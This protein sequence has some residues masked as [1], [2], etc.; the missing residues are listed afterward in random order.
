MKP[1][2]L[3]TGATGFAG[4]H[5]ADHL[6]AHGYPVRV[7]VRETSDVS[8]VHPEAERFVGDVRDPDSLVA[9]VRGV[10]WVF[11]FGGLIRARNRQEFMRANAD[12]TRHLYEAF[13]R[14]SED[15][16]L[17]LFC[18]SLAAV[19]PGRG[20]KLLVEDDPPHPVTHYGASKL[21]AEEFL[22]ARERVEAVTSGARTR[23]V[24]V[25][26]PAV[27][28]PRDP[29]NLML[30]RAISR[31]WIP[32]PA[33]RGARVAAIHAEDLARGCRQLAERSA[34]EGVFH[35]SDG[36]VYSWQELGKIIAAILEVRA[37]RLPIPGWAGYLAALTAEMW[38]RL[39]NRPPLFSRDKIKE[40]RQR[41]Y[42][43]S[44][45]K[46]Q[47]TADFNPRWKIAAGLRQ[48]LDWYRASGWL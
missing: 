26:P 33:P 4:S 38:G 2:V 14:H 3:V 1:A 15:P 24:I 23:I 11:H 13:V 30:I 21:A 29:S 19:G 8:W 41:L 36:E 32:L 6:I 9:M 12:G 16:R 28:G 17:F 10:Q 37:R 27:Y 47:A 22:L 5:A 46:A 7:L 48:T 39:W 34:A 40:L 25:R 20:G 18:S 45:A 43:C 44:I 35:L 31:G 42:A